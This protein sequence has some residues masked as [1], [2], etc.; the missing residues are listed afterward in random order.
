MIYRA[1]SQPAQREARQCAKEL[2]AIGVEVVTAMSGA[3]INPFP[4]L[5]ANEQGMPDLA[6]VLG[7]GTV[8]ALRAIWPYM[9]S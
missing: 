1:E 2:R 5:L 6:V 3:R 4:G 9:T 8:L 7:D